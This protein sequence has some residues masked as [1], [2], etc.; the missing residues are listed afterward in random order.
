ME[1]LELRLCFIVVKRK[2]KNSVLIYYFKV[3]VISFNKYFLPFQ[4]KLN[5]EKVGET[6]EI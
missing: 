1:F 3:K 6:Q 5:I 4:N 2:K